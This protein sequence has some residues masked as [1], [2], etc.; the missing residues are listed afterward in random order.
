MQ[1]PLRLVSGCETDLIPRLLHRIATRGQWLMVAMLVT[2]LVISPHFTT[3]GADLA[4]GPNI[5]LI[6][7]D[8]LGHG[9]LGCYGHPVIQTPNLV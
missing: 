7:A 1:N 3:F 9:D 2:F 5:V 4:S 8:D 6:L